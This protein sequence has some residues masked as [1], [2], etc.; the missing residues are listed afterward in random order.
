[1][2]KRSFAFSQ[3]VTLIIVILPIV[4]SAQ[5]AFPQLVKL[6]AD[7][8]IAEDMFA[9]AVAVSGNTVIVGASE[10]DERGVNSGA[11]YIFS[12]SESGNNA[13]LQV[14]KL[15]A[16]D[17]V[18]GNLFG[19]A[20]ALAGDTAVVGASEADNQR[21]SVYIFECN[22]GGVDNWGQVAKLTASDGVAS[23]RF[24]YAVS[25]SGDTVIVGAD[26]DDNQG[27]A[28]IFSRAAGG[29]NAWG[30]VAKLTASDGA[31]GDFFGSA[32]AISGNTAIVGARRDDDQG[33]G[34][35]SAYIFSRDQ[36]G[37]N[38]WRQVTKI[39]ASDGSNFDNFGFAVAISGDTAVVGA[40]END[41]QGPDSGAA[42]V[43]ERDQGGT[44]NWG[45]VVKLIASDGV[46]NDSFGWSVAISGDT[47]VVGS[48]AND[49][50]DSDSGA[51]YVFERNQG[52]ATNWGEVVKLIASDGARGDRFGI[53]VALSGQTA[54]IGADGGGNQ[55]SDLGAAYVFL[56]NSVIDISS[57][58]TTIL[59]SNQSNAAFGQS[60]ANA[61]DI[62]GDGFADLI[63]GSP[64]F[65]NGEENEGI[66][67]VF[68]GIPTGISNTHSQQLEIDQEGAQFGFAV[69]GIGDINNDGFDDVAVGAPFFVGPPFFVQG[70]VDEGGVF[71]YL[72]STD[73]LQTPAFRILKGDQAGAMMGFS[74]AGIGDVNDDGFAD[75][76]IGLPGFSANVQNRQ[77]RGPAVTGAIAALLGGLLDA[78]NENPDIV[79]AGT[80]PGAALGS[81]I[82]GAGDVNGDNI[83]DI[84]AGS[85]GRANGAF[86]N[87]GAATVYPGS[88]TG[89]QATALVEFL[90]TVV[91]EALGSSVVG[92]GDVNDDGFADVAAGAPGFS[93][94]EEAEGAVHIYLGG[95]NPSL[96]PERS[97]ESNT[98][99]AQLGASVARMDDLNSDGVPEIIAG[100]PRY[101]DGENEE[102][103]A[104]V[105][106]SR[107]P[108]YDDEPR[109]ILQRNQPEAEFGASVAA[110]GVFNVRG[111][112]EL[113]VGA[114]QADEDQNDEG[115][116]SLFAV[117][118]GLTLLI[119]DFDG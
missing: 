83:D 112:T 70:E 114:P 66:V 72:G 90:G 51:A 17:G 15:T 99:N 46:A 56:A 89:P 28:Y 97:L 96:T 78:I 10:H 31:A 9:N 59:E 105:F 54:V 84:I 36:V 69:A 21:G 100:A 12:R 16:S 24:G 118:R 80:Q 58:P 108:S 104:F 71:I 64:L 32:A 85:P 23:D 91:N 68:L 82:A 79:I 26:R 47:A 44:D 6:T 2:H 48:I 38:V 93:N 41:A 25:I 34:S 11:A 67:R 8:S 39:T 92:L 45:E 65:D 86:T 37:S 50:Q 33:G 3:L 109:S 106:T 52:G 117:R 43:F 110:I 57:T 63:A 62:N 53:A 7:D 102:G 88:N 18:A 103:A 119:D 77:A 75:V 116:V 22:E 95:T 61:G 27:A 55:S 101:S 73:G 94:G 111:F 115:T 60:V 40:R 76:G 20:V 35:G 98:V 19:C 49:G 107:F 4:A 74:V 1:M 87:A 30:Q 42:Y 113:V 29:G 81:S 13:W 14:A 5:N